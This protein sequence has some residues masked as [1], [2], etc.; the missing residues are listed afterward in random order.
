M[1]ATNTIAYQARSYSPSAGSAVTSAEPSAPASEEVDADLSGFTEQSWK[2]LAADLKAADEYWKN[3][4]KGY[5]LDEVHA[6]CEQMKLELRR[7]Y[8]AGA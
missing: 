8:S 6:H 5:T 4:G 1:I 2:N 7:K 3:G